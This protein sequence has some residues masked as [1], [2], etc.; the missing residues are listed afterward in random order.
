MAWP[1]EDP[2][3]WSMPAITT[4]CPQGEGVE[5]LC[6]PG[7]IVWG[8]LDLRRPFVCSSSSKT[9]P[10]MYALSSVQQSPHIQQSPPI[11]VLHHWREGASDGERGGGSRGKDILRLL[12]ARS[13]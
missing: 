4:S 2:V 10:D 3:T 7:Y 11:G 12:S 1:A 9:Q 13:L 8:G 6:L 5:H